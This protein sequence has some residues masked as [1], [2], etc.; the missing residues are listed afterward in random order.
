[1]LSLTIHH[2]YI[3]HSPYTICT[4]YRSWCHSTGRS[5]R[6]CSKPSR[7]RGVLAVEL[8]GVLDPLEL[9]GRRMLPPLQRNRITHCRCYCSHSVYT[10]LC[11]ITH[12]RYY[13]S[14]S[15]YTMLCT[16][17]HCRYYC[18]HSVYTMLCTIAHCGYDALCAI[19]HTLIPHHTLTHGRYG[20]LCTMHY[21]LCTMHS[22]TPHTH[23]PH[24]HI[25]HTHIPHTRI[26]H[27]HIPHTR[28]TAHAFTAHTHAHAFTPAIITPP[29]C[30]PTRTLHGRP[31][32]TA[33]LQLLLHSSSR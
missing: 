31:P 32:P 11:T 29:I 19:T 22:L 12:C 26:P 5:A 23:T 17:T 14:H 10:M 18:S 13:C 9:R 24:T 7:V 28:I 6:I 21:A 4:L 2:L 33:P 1:M 30:R 27:T 20:A 3:A 16:I 25:P 8:R 15:V